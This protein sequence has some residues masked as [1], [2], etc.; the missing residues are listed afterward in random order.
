LPFTPRVKF[1]TLI[2]DVATTGNSGS[3]V[4]DP[5]QKCL[6]GI[7][8]SKFTTHTTEGERD[9]A[10]FFVPAAQIRSFLPAEPHKSQ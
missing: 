5:N 10:K 3:G 9:V 4:F 2:A 7:M 6:L 8:S 1:N